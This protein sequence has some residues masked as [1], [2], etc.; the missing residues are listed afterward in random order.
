MSINLYLD[1]DQSA[2]NNNSN[3][4]ST[5]EYGDMCLTTCEHGMGK[6]FTSIMLTVRL[7]I[8]AIKPALVN[9]ATCV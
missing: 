1:K 8:T 4:T 2:L 5:S 3:Q 9:M 7:I 6:A